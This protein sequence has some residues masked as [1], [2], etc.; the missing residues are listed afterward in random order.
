MIHQGKKI[1]HGTLFNMSRVSNLPMTITD[2]SLKVDS[3]SSK[4]KKINKD[5]NNKNGVEEHD[6]EPFIK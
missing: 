4:Q 6:A 3:S 2:T 5:E 1:S